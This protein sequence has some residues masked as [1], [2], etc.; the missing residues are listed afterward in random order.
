MPTL[1]KMTIIP[2]AYWMVTLEF[3]FQPSKIEDL[4]FDCVILFLFIVF[5]NQ[6]AYFVH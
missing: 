5:V 1:M 3:Y 2:M 6:S 4:V